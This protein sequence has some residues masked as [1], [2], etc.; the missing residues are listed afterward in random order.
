MAH[1]DPTAPGGLERVRR[2]VNTMNADGPDELAVPETAARW[3]RENG[4]LEGSS[5][6]DDA[7]VALLRDFR[8]AVREALLAHAGDGDAQ[9]AWNR[10]RALAHDV[11]LRMRFGAAPGDAQL[12]P[13]G[14]G[15]QESLGRLVAAIYDGSRAGTWRRLKACRQ[16]TCLW[17]FYDHSKNSSGT[18]CSMAVCGNRAKAKRRRQRLAT[19]SPAAEL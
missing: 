5:A 7:A 11:P 16:H 6:L 17:A 18:W 2:F 15:V 14:S 4:L 8:E 19:K 3:L 13:A 12:H 1:K 9:A 10:V